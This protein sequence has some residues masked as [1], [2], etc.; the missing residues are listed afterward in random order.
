MQ[1]SIEPWPRAPVTSWPDLTAVARWLAASST[2]PRAT[3][4]KWAHG[5]TAIL[6]TGMRWD[7]AEI[8]LALSTRAVTYLRDRSEHIG[9]HLVSGTDRLYRWLIPTGSTDALPGGVVLP[10]GAPIVAPAPGSYGGEQLWLVPE[11]RPDDKR[12]WARLTS[13]EALRA[14][15]TEAMRV[16]LRAHLE[17]SRE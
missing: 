7:I 1:K 14:A 3:Y 9:L 11:A 8:D 12:P 6:T 2:T 17:Q 5:E 13:A 10:S 4:D 16:H 15:I